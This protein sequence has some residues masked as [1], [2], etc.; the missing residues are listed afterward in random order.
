MVGISPGRGLA[1]GREDHLLA[2]LEVERRREVTDPDAGALQ[3]DQ[4][5]R[6]VAAAL[7]STAGGRGSSGCGSPACRGRR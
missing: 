1:L 5:R 6:R 2:R 3:V 4:D 7:P